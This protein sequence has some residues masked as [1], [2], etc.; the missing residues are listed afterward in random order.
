MSSN[1]VK[2]VG[3]NVTFP[4]T[5]A[6]VAVHYTLD[7]L[8]DDGKRTRVDDSRARGR[9]L[10]FVLGE[11]TV[12]PWLS[13]TVREMSLGELCVATV[14]PEKAY[15]T[16]GFPLLKIPPSATLEAEIELLAIE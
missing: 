4:Q 3:D 5:G 1:R 14:P 12:L 13:E 7:V 2:Q 9:P 10:R 6:D 8:A 15:G 16:A 11:G